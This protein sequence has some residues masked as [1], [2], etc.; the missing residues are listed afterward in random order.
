M[1]VKEKQHIIIH[2]TNIYYILIMSKTQVPKVGMNK[3]NKVSALID[4]GKDSESKTIYLVP[5]VIMNSRLKSK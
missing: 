3:K 5:S 2:L 1:P 4:K